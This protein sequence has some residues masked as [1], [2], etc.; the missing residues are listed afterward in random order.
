M[1]IF[2]QFGRWIFFIQ[3]VTGSLEQLKLCTKLCT[4]TGKERHFYRAFSFLF[5]V[6]NAYTGIFLIYIFFCFVFKLCRRMWRYY[7]AKIYKNLPP[8]LA[9]LYENLTNV[10]NPTLPYA[11]NLTHKFMWISYCFYAILKKKR[12]S[13]WR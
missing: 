1:C 2:G 11:L 3:A 5:C 10:G 4:K 7:R 6:Q 9:V 8:Y 12:W 13:I